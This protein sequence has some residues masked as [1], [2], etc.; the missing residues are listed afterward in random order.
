[1]PDVPW[2]QDTAKWGNV[3]VAKGGLGSVTKSDIA[4][5]QGLI[6]NPAITTICIP[7]GRS[8]QIDADVFI[9]GNI[10]R[11]VGTGGRFIGSGRLVVTGDGTQPVIKIERVDG[12]PIVDQSN[13]KVIIESYIGNISSTGTGDLFISDVCS[14]ATINAPSQRVWAW[15]FNAE[16][17]SPAPKLSVQNV[18]SMR[19]VGW[20]DEPTEQSL[21]FT[22]GILEI[23]GF[24]FYA[25]WSTAGMTMFVI[26]D[27]AQFSAACATQ[28]SFNGN[29]FS[30]IVQET[31]AGVTKMLTSS[32]NGGSDMA[33]Y[34]GYEVAKIPADVYTGIRQ[35]I[36]E[37]RNTA[38]L[39]I[40]SDM[41][42]MLTIS[43]PGG[44]PAHVDL[45]SASGAHATS[46][47]LQAGGCSIRDLPAGIYRA[48]VSGKGFR[49]AASIAFIGHAK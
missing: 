49:I 1:M 7:A 26:Q 33:L 13:K 30:N 12:I 27:G 44:Q 10:K 37:I 46:V 47:L 4:A 40:S 21:T 22:K 19:I 45:Y 6:D 20:K 34:T 25:S 8:Y 5:L 2:E 38:D 17:G 23:L 29:A 24:M 3:W 35:P 32:A 15:Q 39:R 41:H 31:R 42:G 48:I 28:T 43:W 16:G 36:R 14:H 9:R 11:I 18:Y